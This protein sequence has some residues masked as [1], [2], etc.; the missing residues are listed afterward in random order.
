[1]PSF[2]VDE[3]QRRFLLWWAR[4][5]NAPVWFIEE[6]EKQRPETLKITNWKGA[7]K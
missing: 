7:R 6:L 2:Y 1:M 3:Q 5:Y 4:T